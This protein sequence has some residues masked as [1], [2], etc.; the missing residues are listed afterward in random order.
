MVLGSSTRAPT[1]NPGPELT[2]REAILGS[3]EDPLVDELL[4][5][6][7]PLGELLA[8]RMFGGVGLYC[9]GVFFGLLAEGA[10]YFKV[11]E[12]NV[13]AYR[14]AGME[15]FRPYPGQAPSVLGYYE[16]PLEV[17]E[18]RERL[19]AWAEGALAAARRRDAAKTKTKRPAKKGA[20][21]VA[22]AVPLEKLLNL[23]PQS[24]AWLR[25]AGITTAAEL[26][27]LGAVETYRRVLATGVAPT[28]NL[29]YALEGAR[30]GLRHDRLSAEVKE[31]LRARLG[32]KSR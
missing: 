4:S 13:G 26:E 29:L 1:L 24:A 25:E 12:A 21:R 30:L 11:D 8:R 9:D 22:R 7:A 5:D 31:N 28:L 16:V 18:R 19:L 2:P 20:K 10:L 6:L 15:P 32:R 23:G 17:Q 14:A 3:V 27:R